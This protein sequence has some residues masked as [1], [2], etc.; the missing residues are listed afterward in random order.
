MVTQHGELAQA[1]RFVDGAPDISSLP[2]DS[3]ADGDGD[4]MRRYY[5]SQDPGSSVRLHHIIRSDPGVILHDHP[6]DFVS[7]ILAGGYTEV[8]P[9]GETR[10][11]APCVLVRKAEQPHRLIIDGDA[12]TFIA[13]GTV[14]RRW[15]FHTPAGWM[16]WRSYPSGISVAGCADAPLP[17][18]PPA[19][20]RSRWPTP[21]AAAP[22]WPPTRP[23]R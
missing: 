10:Y 16:H 13:C 14:R 23:R 8:T 1:L 22:S 4:Y 7:L 2:C 17:P 3:L 15:G 9:D 11:E 12:W 6:W 21:P 5:V 18:P 19:P 20:S